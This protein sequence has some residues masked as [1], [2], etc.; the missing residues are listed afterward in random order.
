MTYESITKLASTNHVK[1]RNYRNGQC[2]D[3]SLPMTLPHIMLSYRILNAASQ[4]HEAL[5]DF[6]DFDFML[7][8]GETET[9]VGAAPD[10]PY[11]KNFRKR[12]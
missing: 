9:S 6:C 12:E 7:G 5:S 11:L 2:L 4:R 8:Q 1:A 10:F 3:F